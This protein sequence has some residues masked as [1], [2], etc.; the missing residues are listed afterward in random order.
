MSSSVASTIPLSEKAFKEKYDSAAVLT[1][2][3]FSVSEKIVSSH[4]LVGVSSTMMMLD[5]SG[6]SINENV[7]LLDGNLLMVILDIMQTDSHQHDHITLKT[8]TMLPCRCFC[9]HCLEPQDSGQGGQAV[10][11]EK[12]QLIYLYLKL[13]NTTT[14]AFLKM[15]WRAHL[16]MNPD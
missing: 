11:D 10:P 9:P 16:A 6:F 5:S 7:K 4:S 14:W 2:F 12:L 3:V 1:L 13:K 15:H 8:L